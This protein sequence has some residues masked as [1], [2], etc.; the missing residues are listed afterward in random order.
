MQTISREV[1]NELYRSL[2]LLGADNDLCGTVG[3]W[4]TSLPEED[5][6]ANLKSWNEATLKETRQRIEHY[7]TSCLHPAYSP[8]GVRGSNPQEQ[9]AD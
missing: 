8:V 6:L 2:V 9:Q 5:V 7:E 1:V 3:S 4:G